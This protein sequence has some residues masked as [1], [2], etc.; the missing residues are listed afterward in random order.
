MDFKSLITCAHF[1][2]SSVGNQIGKQLYNSFWGLFGIICKKYL[3]VITQT[4]KVA[5]KRD[6]LS[7][8]ARIFNP[9]IILSP[10]SVTLKIMIQEIW[11]YKTGWND[12]ILIEIKEKWKKSWDEILELADLNILRYVWASGEAKDVQIPGFCDSS[13]VAY[14]AI[15]Y[16]RAVSL[17]MTK[18]YGVMCGKVKSRLL[19]LKRADPAALS[20]HNIWWQGPTW[21]KDKNFM[22]NQDNYNDQECQEEERVALSCHAQASDS[23]EIVTKYSTFNKKKLT[24][25]FSKFA[26]NSL[27][28][29]PLKTCFTVLQTIEEKYA[30][31]P[32]TLDNGIKE[33]NIQRVFGQL[34][35]GTEER[36]KAN[37]QPMWGPQGLFIDDPCKQDRFWQGVS[38]RWF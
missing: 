20:R 31:V 28:Q 30:M 1:K 22:H 25:A 36:K 32:F 34:V 23:V 19:C 6:L 17:W 33:A 8:I 27:I 16:L 29:L 35:A 37:T 24:G 13:S 7:N 2:E 3:E 21:L 18:G 14:L 11:K 38:S 10:T 12:C 5:T 9:I 4:N 26:E 15:C